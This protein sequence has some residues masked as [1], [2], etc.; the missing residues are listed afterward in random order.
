[1][2]FSGSSGECGL[3]E[4][5]ERDAAEAKFP[6]ALERSLAPM[7]GCLMA[8]VAAIAV[9]ACNQSPFAYE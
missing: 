6:D 3:I 7:R 9:G 8:I 5:N 4:I 2:Q 1:V